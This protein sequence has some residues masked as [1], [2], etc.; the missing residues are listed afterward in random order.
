MIND[1][2]SDAGLKDV[3]DVMEPTSQSARSQPHSTIGNFYPANNQL[4]NGGTLPPQQ[5]HIKP[6][7]MTT[8][9]SEPEKAPQPQQQ[10]IQKPK[11]E[12]PEEKKVTEMRAPIKDT[13]DAILSEPGT[14]TKFKYKSKN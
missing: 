3:D 4:M 7:N 13:S 8:T 14:P 9:A 6:V 5:Q 10:R 11:I 1:E 2:E 12:A